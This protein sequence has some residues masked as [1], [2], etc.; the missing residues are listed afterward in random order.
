M[1]SSWSDDASPYPP[2]YVD[3][4]PHMAK[5]EEVMELYASVYNWQNAADNLRKRRAAVGNECGVKYAEK[6]NVMAGPQAA[7]TYLLP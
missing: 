3:I 7:A 2:F 6:F 1:R 4:T 5:I